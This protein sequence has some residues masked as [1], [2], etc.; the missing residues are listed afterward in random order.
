MN[1]HF[2]GARSFTFLSQKCLEMIMY[3]LFQQKKGEKQN[4]K[5]FCNTPPLPRDNY[6][7]TGLPNTSCKFSVRVVQL[8]K[9]TKNTN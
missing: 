5:Q 2:S 9:V 4:S 3:I 1:Q 7:T 8:K 6:K